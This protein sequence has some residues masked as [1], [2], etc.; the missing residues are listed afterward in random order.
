MSDEEMDTLSIIT[1]DYALL[2]IFCFP[3]FFYLVSRHHVR[4]STTLAS[5]ASP[6][7][8]DFRSTIVGSLE[9]GFY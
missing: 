4:M 6:T 8:I 2:S 9:G 3:I 7:A 1:V 5:L